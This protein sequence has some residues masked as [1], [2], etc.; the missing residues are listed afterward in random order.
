MSDSIEPAIIYSIAFYV[1]GSLGCCCWDYWRKIKIVTNDVER[2]KNGTLGVNERKVDNRH[3]H[4]TTF[5]TQLTSIIIIL[6]RRLVKLNR[7][8]E[9]AANQMPQFHGKFKQFQLGNNASVGLRL[10]G[11]TFSGYVHALTWTTNLNGCSVEQTSHFYYLSLICT[12]DK[13]W[14]TMLTFSIVLGR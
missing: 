7:R 10:F 9:D 1:W 4:E 11:R 12:H 6:H 2:M 8:M 3:S 14:S 5:I 13:H